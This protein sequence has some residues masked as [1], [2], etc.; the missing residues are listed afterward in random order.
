MP[1][2]TFIP[3]SKP[4]AMLLLPAILRSA[5]NPLAVLLSPVVLLMSAPVP[6]AVLELPVG[7][8][9]AH[10]GTNR[11]VVIPVGCKECA[12][13]LAVFIEAGGVAQ[14]RTKTVGR[15]VTPVVLSC[16]ALQYSFAVL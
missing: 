4:N 11:R 7:C 14:K 2:V 1:V 9:K 13:P 8:H 15:I 3:A 10:P 16:S 12:I 5:S 6:F